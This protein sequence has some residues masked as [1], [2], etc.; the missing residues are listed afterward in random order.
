MPRTRRLRPMTDEE[1]VELERLAR[2]RSEEI[3][4]VERAKAILLV[5][6]GQPIQVAAE[7][8]RRHAQTVS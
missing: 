7:Q 5:Y 4:L 8:V 1:R 3:R 6:A 2:S